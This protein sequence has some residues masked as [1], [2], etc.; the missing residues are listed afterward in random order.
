MI[1]PQASYRFDED[2]A[3]ARISGFLSVALSLPIVFFGSFSLSPDTVAQPSPS[4]QYRPPPRATPLR[5]E[6]AGVRLNEEY[7]IDD[8]LLSAR[9]TQSLP[10][11]VSAVQS[12]LPMPIIR[13]KAERN[14]S[15]HG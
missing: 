8:P 15:C 6:S 5:T 11:L 4:V 7:C 14:L 1:Q 9:L 3:M 2:T 10:R 13:P 12:M